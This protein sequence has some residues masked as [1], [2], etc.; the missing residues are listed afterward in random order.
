[1]SRP[2]RAAS[3]VADSRG[4]TRPLLTELRHP[5]SAAALARLSRVAASILGAPIAHVT[6]IAENE[7]YYFGS[8]RPREGLVSGAFGP[9]GCH[10]RSNTCIACRPRRRSAALSV[11]VPDVHVDQETDPQARSE[12]AARQV[13]GSFGL[14]VGSLGR[15]AHRR[16]RARGA[17]RVSEVAQCGRREG[18]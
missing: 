14:C 13:G 1:M 11:R 6:L 10:A 17:R 16:C 4:A 15:G 5:D 3:L 18:V 2:S 7:Q 9:A 12:Y 8:Y